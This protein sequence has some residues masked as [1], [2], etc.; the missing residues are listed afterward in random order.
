MYHSASITTK[1]MRLFCRVRDTLNALR[2][3]SDFFTLTSELRQEHIKRVGLKRYLAD[4]LSYH[5]GKP[6]SYCTAWYTGQAPQQ[7]PPTMRTL[8][9]LIDL[10]EN[11]PSGLP[12]DRVEIR[13]A[14]TA[15]FF[16][17]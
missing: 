3:Q 2:R 8:D 14:G 11:H 17:I 16:S 13:E 5:A 6:A 9:F 12:P 7:G 4:M 1:E 15:R 10:T